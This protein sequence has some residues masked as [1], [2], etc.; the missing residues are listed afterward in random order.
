MPPSAPSSLASPS[1]TEL[2]ANSTPKRKVIPGRPVPPHM[3]LS[4]QSPSPTPRPEPL[5]LLDAQKAVMEGLVTRG[6]FQG[7]WAWKCLVCNFDR[8]MMCL[9]C[10][11]QIKVY[12]KY[13][14]ERHCK[15]KHSDLWQMSE[16]EK[17]SILTKYVGKCGKWMGENCVK[18]DKSLLKTALAKVGPIR[19]VLPSEP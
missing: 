16:Q 4:P 1:P 2:A 13:N 11:T 5:T 9:V 12:K 17:R 15:D 8:E 19:P 14:V 10:H 3:P 18:G 7:E 6:S